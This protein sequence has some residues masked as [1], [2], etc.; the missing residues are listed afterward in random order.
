MF[1]YRIINEETN[2]CLP[3]PHFDKEKAIDLA[4]DLKTKAKGKAEFRVVS[5]I[6]I[7]STKEKDQ[8]NDIEF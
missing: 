8:Q 2:E 4:K 6:P 7:F 5:V 1:V 3:D